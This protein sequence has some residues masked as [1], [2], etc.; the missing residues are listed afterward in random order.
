M[1]TKKSSRELELEKDGW[2]KK[3]TIENHRVE[4][5]VE[6]Y[7]SLRFEVL[8]EPIESNAPSETIDDCNAC[9]KEFRDKYKTIYTRAKK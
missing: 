8:V 7:K 2:E 1:T 4:E 3:F 6:L 9:F 5:F